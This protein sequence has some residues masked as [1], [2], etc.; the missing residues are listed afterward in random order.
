MFGR[1]WRTVSLLKFRKQPIF[2][3]K[4]NPSIDYYGRLGVPK[5][6]S[7]DEIKKAFYRL[8]KEYHPDSKKGFED[9]FK[10]INEAYTVLSDPKARR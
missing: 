2:D 7:D 6:A 1:S 9:K 8:A 4:F 5:T 3:A 10:E